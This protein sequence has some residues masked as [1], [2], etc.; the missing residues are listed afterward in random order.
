MKKE[1]SHL[2]Q[3]VEPHE[4]EEIALELEPQGIPL[5]LLGGNGMGKSKAAQLASDR[6]S[7]DNYGIRKPTVDCNSGLRPGRGE[8]GR[9]MFNATCYDPEDF[10]MPVINDHTYDRYVTTSL[11]GADASW[12]K[13]VEWEDIHC[14]VIAEEI[15]KKPENFKIWAELFNERTLGTNYKVPPKTYFIATSNN[16]EDGAGAFDIHNDLIR[17]VCDVQVRATVEG[18]LN[19]HKGELHPLITSILKYQGESFLFTQQDEANGKAFCSPATVFQ[20]NKLLS[21]GLDMDSSLSEAMV[22]GIIGIRG[23]AALVATYRAGKNF[24]DL[25]EM[26][27]DPDKH[28]DKIDQLRNDTTHNGR[29]TLCS[30]ICMLVARLDKKR[31]TYNRLGGA[32]QINNIIKFV[33]RI[34][35]EASVACVSAALAL[36]KDI[37]KEAEFVK[38]YANNQ[39]FYF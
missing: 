35:Q 3:T 34:D 31:S 27:S 26:L 18:F 9:V 23:G 20:V 1:E 30:I 12:T 21:N 8:Y 32:G 37:E 19:Y 25:D 15:G 7:H 39:D 4:V 10:A 22:L 6:I 13:N 28:S 2:R 5:L 38:H 17:R 29:Q 14:T 16:A 11:P 24:G 33:D 36:N